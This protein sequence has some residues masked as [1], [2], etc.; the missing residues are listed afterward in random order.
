MLLGGLL[1]LVAGT[2]LLLVAGGFRGVDV[3]VWDW[4]DAY[5]SPR[6]RTRWGT[7]WRSPGWMRTQFGAVGV[8]LVIVGLTAVTR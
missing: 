6:Y 3:R 5:F 7:P 1:A 8:G 4:A 2:G